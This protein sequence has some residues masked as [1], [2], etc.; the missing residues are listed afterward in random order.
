ML[1][2]TDKSEYLILSRGDLYYIAA[3]NISQ[4]EGVEHIFTTRLGGVSSPPYDSLNLEMTTGDSI[5]L[6]TANR[7]FFQATFGVELISF[8]RQVHGDDVL[9]IE[10]KAE[11][12]QLRSAKAVPT[13]DALITSVENVPLVMYYADCVSV[14]LCDQYRKVIALVHAGWRSTLSQIS[15][16]TVRVFREIF[17]SRPSDIQGWI[18]PSIGPCCLQVGVDVASKFSECFPYGDSLVEK[19]S[20]KYF[21]DLWKANLW[22]IRESGISKIAVSRL[23]TSCNQRLF[24]SYRRD[25]G[26]TGRMAGVIVLKKEG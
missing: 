26:V 15:A 23:C 3:P 18:G 9:V 25:K 4:V 8:S 14:F 12:E 10:H 21:L 22:Q 17:H 13:C 24:Y 2:E 20:D 5:E 11:W 6:V 19:R 7:S 1:V 16:K